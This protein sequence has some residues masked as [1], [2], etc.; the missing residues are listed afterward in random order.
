M[1]IN[2]YKTLKDAPCFPHLKRGVGGEVKPLIIKQ[3]KTIKQLQ[4][5]FLAVLVLVSCTDDIEIVP[6][7]AYENGFF[8]SNEGKFDSDTAEVTFISYDGQ[9]VKQDVF[10]S[11]NNGAVLGDTQQSITFY[12][13][14]AFLILNVSNKIEVVNRY[15]FKRIT[16]INTGLNNP[17]YMAFVN[18]K[19]YITNWGAGGNPDDDFVAVI[20]LSTYMVETTIAVVEGPEKVVAHQNNLYVA[21][22]GGWGINN[23]ISVISTANNSVTAFIEV[24]DV[25]KALIIHNNQ[26]L[27]L[28]SGRGSWQI[29]GPTNGRLD[30]INLTNNEVST[31]NS[32]AGDK[33]SDMV[34]YND[35]LYYTQ[36]TKVFK[37]NPNAASFA[38][39]EILNVANY[40]M[41]NPYGFNVANDKIYICDAKT[42]NVDGSLK[43][44][45]LSGDF[46]AE[47]PTRIGPNGVVFN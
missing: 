47:F 2:L 29:G 3:M 25:P 28:S 31:F 46:Q 14:K 17:R 23:K 36:G 10:K 24:G 30:K 32:F 7:G 43:I 26:L 37:T 21:H 20:N 5:L 13:D 8:V 40:N 6:L 16:T 11:E 44:F 19:G 42:F 38:S 15:T 45:N 27:V 4:F 34:M 22:Q 18:G 12:E 41:G 39:Q 33:P 1:N 9:T 35:E